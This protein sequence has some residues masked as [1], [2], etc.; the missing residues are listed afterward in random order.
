MKYLLTTFLLLFSITLSAQTTVVTGPKKKPQTTT[1][2]AKPKSA[3]PAAKPQTKPTPKP[4]QPKVNPK[5]QPKQ[6]SISSPTG[7]ENGRGYV[8]LGLSVKWATCNV[9]ASSPTDY[10]GYF[11]WGETCTKSDYSWRTYFDS[12]SRSNEKFHNSNSDFYKY[13]ANK[14]TTLDLSD[15]AAHVN[16]GGSWRMP[17][18]AELD[19]L[20]EKCTWTWTT[21]NGTKGY[22]VS[23][24]R[25]GN[26]IF[27]PAAGAIIGNSN[28]DANFGYYRSS[29]LCTGSQDNE[30]TLFFHS[31]LVDR[32]FGHDR[33]YG[34]S[35]RA[36]CK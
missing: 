12:V 11:A 33:E 16:W 1:T 17:S 3:T 25:N 30:W 29:S 28:F 19:E 20:R 14:K 23:S 26:S 7:Y 8:D 27:L 22:R 4:Q 2:P 5:P 34:F 18:R 10:G 36:V 21:Q 32:P 24:K 6:P 31:D 9:G 15:D 35:V 13:A